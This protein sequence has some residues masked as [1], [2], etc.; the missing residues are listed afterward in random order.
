MEHQK[1]VNLELDIL[2]DMYVNA[3]SILKEALLEG[4]SWETLQ[5]YRHDV[6]ELEIALYNKVRSANGNPAENQNRSST[7]FEL[8]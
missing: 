5:E 6:T 3:A 8:S 4:A 2:K 7:E 1:L